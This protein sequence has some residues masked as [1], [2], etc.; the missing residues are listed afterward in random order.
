MQVLKAKEYTILRDVK[1]G[2]KIAVPVKPT[3]VATLLNE[4][5]FE[6][7]GGL[8]IHHETVFHESEMH[9]WDWKDGE[10]KFG[11]RVFGEEDDPEYTPLSVVL[12]YDSEH[13]EYTR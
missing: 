5:L 12:V 9:D 13:V 10:F 7:L 4:A 11:S 8:M 3:R 1:R 2:E 6:K